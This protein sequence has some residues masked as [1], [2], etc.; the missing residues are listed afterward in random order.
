MDWNSPTSV[1][2]VSEIGDT[3]DPEEVRRLYWEE[4]LSAPDI[5]GRFGVSYDSI[6]KIMRE[7][8]IPIRS[9]SDAATL[10]MG[11]LNNVISY[12]TWTKIDPKEVR[13]LYWEEGLSTY[14]VAE[15]LQVTQTRI[16]RVMRKFS[17]P[18]R[19]RVQ[20]LKVATLAKGSPKGRKDSHGY[21]EVKIYSDSPYYPMARSGG[22]VM[23][24]RLVMAQHLGRCLES[25]EIVHHV[26]GVKDDNRYENLKLTTQ[27]RH[28]NEDREMVLQLQGEVKDLQARVTL[29]EAENILLRSQA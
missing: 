24:H 19:S 18:R 16:K 29:L 8:N 25:W 27:G 4:G 13:R 1:S 28:K 7:N 23:L 15:R 3:I 20:A 26:N 11:A 14:G 12:G 6:Y 5:A 21:M 2:I 17:I 9:L 10:A 22:Y